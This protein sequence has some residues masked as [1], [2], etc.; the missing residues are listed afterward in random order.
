MAIK[1]TDE[2]VGLLDDGVCNY[3]VQYIDTN[4]LSVDGLSVVTNG[5]LHSLTDQWIV[6][7][8]CTE[9]TWEQVRDC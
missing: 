3:D 4:N 1:C 5:F 7:R 2:G 9:V 8:P 6:V